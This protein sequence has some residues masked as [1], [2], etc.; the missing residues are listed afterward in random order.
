MIGECPAGGTWGIL[1]Y[2]GPDTKR[3]ACIACLCCGP[4]VS[5]PLI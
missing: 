3:N 5:M 4:C 1:K 2:V